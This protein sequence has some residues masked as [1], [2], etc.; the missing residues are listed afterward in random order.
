MDICLGKSVKQSYSQAIHDKIHNQ[1]N[2]QQTRQCRGALMQKVLHTTTDTK[3]M[4]IP[5]IP[6]VIQACRMQQSTQTP[7]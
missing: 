6:K 3:Y 5:A 7:S 1:N 4:A 2:T